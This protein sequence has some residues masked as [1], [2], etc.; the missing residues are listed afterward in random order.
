MI[1]DSGWGKVDK[2]F[3]GEGKGGQVGIMT[4]RRYDGHEK[5]RGQVEGNK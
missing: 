5:G 2:A 4:R 3:K 1:C